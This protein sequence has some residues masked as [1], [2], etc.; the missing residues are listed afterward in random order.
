MLMAK[1]SVDLAFNAAQEAEWAAE[2]RLNETGSAIA[3]LEN[4]MDVQV[5]TIVRWDEVLPLDKKSRQDRDRFLT[6]VKVYRESYPV[7][8]S[9]AARINA[10]LATIPG[11]SPQSICKSGV[12]RLDD[13]HHGI[14]SSNSALRTGAIIE[15]NRLPSNPSSP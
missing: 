4:A 8:G 13:L 12:C 11:R 15:T 3:G 14:V 5:S 9:E 1:P 7:I 2:L 10:L 6:P